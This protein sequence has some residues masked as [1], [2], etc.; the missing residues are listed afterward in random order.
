MQ[1]GLLSLLPQLFLRA[2]MYFMG[3]RF[4]APEK[5]TRVKLVDV[6]VTSVITVIGLYLRS[7]QY[8]L[9]SSGLLTQD[10]ALAVF[11]FA[12][13]LTLLLTMVSFHN[14]RT[15]QQDDRALHTQRLMAQSLLHTLKLREENDEAM[16][17]LRHDLKNHMLTIG[18]M[19]DQGCTDQ[20][21]EYINAFLM[22]SAPYELH[23]QTGRS[24][25]DALMSEKLGHASEEGIAVS[26]VMDFSA[27]NFIS[28]FDLC[29]LMGNALD[30][31]VEGCLALPPES[32]RFIEIKGG[33]SA[34]MLTVRITNS[35]PTERS[36]LLRTTKAEPHK[37]GYGLRIIRST[38]KRYNGLVQTLLD[39]PG[40]FGLVI[41]IPIPD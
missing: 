35:C 32:Q 18:A 20:A 1:P 40:R 7:T 37:H 36:P 14:Y 23:M 5:I 24:M 26:V 25:L 13:Q 27:G 30:N 8:H 11:F 31:A 16:R 6:L 2:L 10:P 17:N 41:S 21:K 15:R 3:Y 38:A 9:I 29:M 12:L 34:N 28:D 19:I 39:T 33:V 4:L 22:R